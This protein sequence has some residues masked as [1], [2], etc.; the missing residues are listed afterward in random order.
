MTT[1]PA[2]LSW[3][4]EQIPDL[5]GRAAVVTGAAGGL[6]LH[7]IRALA[8]HGATV[9]MAVRDPA[10]ARAAAADLLAEAP[11]GQVEVARLDLLDLG[12]V[13]AF[14]EALGSRHGAV[15]LLV[16]NAGASSQSLT[17]SAQG[18]ESQLATNH[19]G[20]FAL[21]GLLLDQLSKGTDP[22]VVTVASA[23]YTTARLDLH[24][25]DGSGGYSPGRAY[26]RSKLANVLFARELQT[27]LERAG[28]PVRSLAA[29]P[30]MARTPLHDTYP[31]PVVRAVTKTLARVIGR[32]AEDA[33]VPLLYAATAPEA[34]PARFYGPAGRPGRPAVRPEAFTGPGLDDDGARRLWETSERITAVRYLTR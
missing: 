1:A 9:V 21:T 23:L 22:R 7:L 12:S 10:R 19:L 26:N 28:S 20:H 14:A 17:L 3:T 34:D 18:V 11:T 4:V 2:P 33:V 27:R 30:G 6:G 25:L 15:D 24:D 32:P 13:H 5:T 8:A 31:S 29:H 16:A